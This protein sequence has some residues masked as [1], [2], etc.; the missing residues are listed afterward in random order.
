MRELGVRLLE[1]RELRLHELVVGGWALLALGLAGLL[2]CSLRHPLLFSPSSPP[3]DFI[4]WCVFEALPSQKC[5]KIRRILQFAR[6]LAWT[7]QY[8]ILLLLLFRRRAIGRGAGGKRLSGVV[9][10]CRGKRRL[11]AHPT[12]TL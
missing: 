4:L 1:L 5:A 6:I 7:L 10:G 9:C 12:D 8:Y 3:F 2:C 11:G